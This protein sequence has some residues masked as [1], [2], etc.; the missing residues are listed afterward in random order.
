M[1][2]RAAA[3]ALALLALAPAGA[4][5]KVVI[6]TGMTSASS[7]SRIAIVGSDR[8]L[9]GRAFQVLRDGAV[10]DRGRLRRAPGD[11][12]PFEHAYRADWS[13]VTEPGAYRLRVG[14]VVSRPWT[15]ADGGGSAAIAAIL[16]YFNANR[17]GAEASAT[18]GPAHLNDAVV[19]PAA[20][21]HGGASVAIAGGW[22]DAGDMLHFTQTTAFSA[23]VLQAAA[24]LDPADAA[25]LNAE[26]DVGVRWLIEA[27]PFPDAFVAQV[28]DER[29]HR[30]G[31]R[32]PATDDASGL[33]GIG[34]R[35]AYVLPADR[36]GGDLGG[37]AATALALAHQRTGDPAQLAAALEWYAAGKLSAAPAPALKRAGY[38]AV[39]GNFYAS[40]IWAD[41]M[42]SAAIELYRSTGD[43][44]YLDDAAGFLARRRRAGR[45][46]A[47]DR[48]QLRLARRGRRLRSARPPPDPGRP[49]AG[50]QL[51]AAARERRDRRAPGALER[52][53]H[54]GLLLLGHDGAERGQRGAGRAVHGG[55]GRLAAR[56]RGGRRRPG[57][58]ARAKPVRRG[59]V[60]GFGRKAPRHPHHWASV[61]GSGLPA[62]AVVGGPAPLEQISEQGFR[63]RGRLQS[64]FA[65]YV[66]QRRNYVTSEPAIDYAAS[67]ILLLAALEAHC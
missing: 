39:A 23:A 57:L 64:E 54:A 14:R 24:R 28:G 65:A 45:R 36:I 7:E 33:E 52:V 2:S 43:A 53:R 56:L 19:H 67:S 9:G 27:H 51:L 34:T 61:F 17:D 21:A 3:L 55:A 18:H 20:F 38:P 32:D 6:R 63:A 49:G 40:T 25:A 42:A 31:F 47:R 1:A 44:S 58:P 30:L 46:H 8:K 15:V 59:F 11:P 29:D 16:G 60:V 10:V 62:G 41:S 13:A 50:A 26:A 12:A 35:L 37:K 4:G 66:D 22:M 48:R 5:A